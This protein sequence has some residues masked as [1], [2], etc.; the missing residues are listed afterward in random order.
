[1]AVN[2]NKYDDDALFIYGQVPI[3]KAEYKQLEA[4]G[5]DLSFV[6]PP[7][8]TNGPSAIGDK[9]PENDIS[10]MMESIVEVLEELTDNNKDVQYEYGAGH[11]STEY[12]PYDQGKTRLDEDAFLGWTAYELGYVDSEIAIQPTA[13][14]LESLIRVSLDTTSAD[15]ID[16]KIKLIDETVN[17]GDIIMFDTPIK[18]GLAGFY[19]G[20]GEFITLF[21]Q[22][23]DDINDIYRLYLWET[24]EDDGSMMPTEWLRRFN[25]GVYRTELLDSEAYKWYNSTI[26]N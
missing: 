12:S 19:L 18:N 2:I 20:S 24:D 9:T 25:G 22:D 6:L 1:M 13:T 21:T 16:Y 8:E 14:I 4:D 17:I 7:G 5:V 26:N 11:D 23:N 10:I 3:T 15:T